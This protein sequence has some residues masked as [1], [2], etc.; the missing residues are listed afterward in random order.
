MAIASWA[1]I[2]RDLGIP[3]LVGAVLGAAITALTQR[4]GRKTEHQLTI[5][6][7]I[8]QEQRAAAS[9]IDQALASL[10]LRVFH[11]PDTANA[12][13]NEWITDVRPTTALIDDLE[14][15]RRVELI[16][17]LLLYA[18]QG[19]THANWRHTTGTCIEDARAWLHAFLGRRPIPSPQFLTIERVREA[20]ATE[21]GPTAMFDLIEVERI[22]RPL[23]SS[24]AGH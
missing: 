10:E 24:T 20:A 19:G 22:A 23:L 15:V 13:R 8:L 2:L 12:L 16:G 1:T 17:E 9:A 6:R 11:G 7:L 18:H 21:G 3:T 14:L 5:E 4:Q